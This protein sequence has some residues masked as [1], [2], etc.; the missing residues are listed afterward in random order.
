MPHRIVAGSE[1][2]NDGIVS[3]ASAKY[4]ERCD[5][6]EGDHL[7]LINWLNPFTHL[8]GLCEERTPYYARLV[9][10]LVDLGY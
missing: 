3:V 10:R 8:R 6:W 2:A 1:G 9:Q 5:V 7:S 4:G